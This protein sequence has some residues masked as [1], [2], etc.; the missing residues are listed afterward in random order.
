MRHPGSSG[1]VQTGTDSKVAP[2]VLPLGTSTVPPMGMATIS[3]S[4]IAAS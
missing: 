3:F 1:R 2:M 4:F